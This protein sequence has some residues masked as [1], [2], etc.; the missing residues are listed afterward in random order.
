M[1]L[2]AWSLLG[3]VK[4]QDVLSVTALPDLEDGEVEETLEDDW[5][6]IIV[7]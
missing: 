1:C 6:A 2:G 7:D 4:D 5:D 3:Y